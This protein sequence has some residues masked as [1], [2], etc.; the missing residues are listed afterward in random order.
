[1]GYLGYFYDLRLRFQCGCGFKSVAANMRLLLILRSTSN[2]ALRKWTSSYE[3]RKSTELALLYTL[4]MRFCVS[5]RMLPQI[6]PEQI[7]KF[8]PLF[9]PI[10]TQNIEICKLN[11]IQLFKYLNT[12]ISRLL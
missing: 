6:V 9:N 3:S 10:S 11:E 7:C 4:L 2:F 1:M 5:L 8:Q 12:I